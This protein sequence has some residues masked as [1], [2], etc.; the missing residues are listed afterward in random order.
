VKLEK[1][2]RSSEE[3]VVTEDKP[4]RT[5]PATD[6]AQS[7][8]E[9]IERSARARESYLEPVTNVPISTTTITTTLSTFDVST[10]ISLETTTEPLP[11]P[12]VLYVMSTS[13]ED[14]TDSSQ[15]T[16]AEKDDKARYQKEVLAKE[17]SQ[18]AE[19]DFGTSKSTYT[20][21]IPSDEH[22]S[23][24]D[25]QEA[26]PMVPP[27]VIYIASNAADRDLDDNN[28]PDPPKVQY[29]SGSIISQTSTAPTSPTTD[30]SVEL[31]QLTYN[32]AHC[33]M[34]SSLF[35]VETLS[36]IAMYC[37]MRILV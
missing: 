20:V 36:L 29:I 37:I 22:I 17:L 5:V 23:I 27:E 4:T 13:T 2:Q 15:L 12:T 33:L 10:G 30:S 21:N 8:K 16:S 26:N 34:P 24:A 28:D 32:Q 7:Y 19:L 9:D 35:K 3:D 31:N 18:L 6:F 11:P 25:I 1:K 14:P